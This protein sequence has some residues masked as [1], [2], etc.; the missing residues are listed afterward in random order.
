MFIKFLTKELLSTTFH[1]FLVGEPVSSSRPANSVPSYENR[2]RI[3][4]CHVRQL[5]R[6]KFIVK[7]EDIT[8]LECIG[9]GI[10]ALSHPAYCIFLGFIPFQGSLA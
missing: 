8:L 9:E 6:G 4:S 3:P 10:I 2:L 7:Y 5:T 1:C